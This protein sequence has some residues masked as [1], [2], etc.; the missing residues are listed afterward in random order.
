MPIH[1]ETLTALHEALRDVVVSGTGRRAQ[2]RDIAI[3]GKTGT[4][5]V[6]SLD[7]VESEDNVP[8]GLRDHAWFVAYAPSD[9]P[10]IAVSVI[11]EH[12]GHGG[13]VAAPIARAIIDEYLQPDRVLMVP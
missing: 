13:T 5:Q 6:V 9:D 12:M 4:A 8:H 10:E 7:K 11:L 2:S 1:H 3:S